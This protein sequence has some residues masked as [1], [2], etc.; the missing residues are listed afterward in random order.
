MK[1][2]R[3]F[4]KITFVLPTT[5]DIHMPFHSQK[6][7]WKTNGRRYEAQSDKDR[8]I[9]RGNRRDISRGNNFGNNIGGKNVGNNPSNR[10][11]IMAKN[12][13]KPSKHG[14]PQHTTPSL[15]DG[16][17]GHRPFMG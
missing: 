4:T 3:K 13:D 16:T 9:N 2:G 11:Q 10:K 5:F 14:T 6:H 8:D 7:V 1:D 12:R 17:P 15:P